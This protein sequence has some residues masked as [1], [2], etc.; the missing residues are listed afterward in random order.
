[1]KLS[2][3]MKSHNSWGSKGRD[4]TREKSKILQISY[5]LGSGGILSQAGM[6]EPSGPSKP[7]CSGT[8]PISSKEE[9][10]ETWG[11]WGNSKYWGPNLLLLLPLR[12]RKKSYTM[13]SEE[14]L[15]QDA[16]PNPLCWVLG[17]AQFFVL[18]AISLMNITFDQNRWMNLG[19]SKL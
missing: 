7:Q 3:P 11:T 4:F 13:E 16:V 14:G 10:W 2:F 1:M 15:Q 5:I 6:L 8:H 18:W 12:S 9:T 19:S 17:F